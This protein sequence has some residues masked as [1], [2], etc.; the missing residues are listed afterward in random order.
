MLPRCSLRHTGPGRIPMTT[1]KL[2]HGTKDWKQR[3]QSGPL[4]NPANCRRTT[5]GQSRRVT[6]ATAT[7]KRFGVPSMYDHKAGGSPK[8]TGSNASGTRS[9]IKP[10]P[11]YMQGTKAS[12][13]RNKHHRR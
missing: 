11:S 10:V 9:W 8:A 13:R 6:E 5:G 1:G 12:S 4:P 7:L 2:F 3:L